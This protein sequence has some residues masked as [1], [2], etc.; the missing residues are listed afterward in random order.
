MFFSMN[1]KVSEVRAR[2][3]WRPEQGRGVWYRVR[4]SRQGR[5]RVGHCHIILFNNHR[6]TVRKVVGTP[7]C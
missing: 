6:S 7:V 1:C 2:E 4:V 5:D 3:I